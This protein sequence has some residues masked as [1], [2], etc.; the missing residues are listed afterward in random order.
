MLADVQAAMKPATSM[1]FHP[2]AYRKTGNP[3]TNHTSREPNRKMRAAEI[4]LMARVFANSSPKDLEAFAFP[5]S[6]GGG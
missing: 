1:Y 2:F 3:T 5:S 6:V 4:R